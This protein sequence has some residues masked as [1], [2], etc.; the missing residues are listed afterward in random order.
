MQDQSDPRTQYAHAALLKTYQGYDYGILTNDDQSIRP[1]QVDSVH[2][3]V[4]VNPATAG[5][6]LAGAVPGKV[7]V[8]GVWNA[9][10][11]TVTTSATAALKVTDKDGTE[12][13]VAATLDLTAIAEAASADMTMI[14]HPSKVEITVTGDPDAGQ[15]TEIGLIVRPARHEWK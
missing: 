10:A 12:Y 1:G 6:Q 8:V 13:D 3:L 15:E 14:P 11:I 9:K 7:H 2:Y 4:P 5:A